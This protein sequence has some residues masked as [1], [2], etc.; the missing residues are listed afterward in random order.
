MAQNPSN[1]QQAAPRLAPIA[2]AIGVAVV[3]VGLVVNLEVIAPVGV[4]IT[5]LAAVAWIRGNNGGSRAAAE[6]KQR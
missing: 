3:L 6:P 1:K 5:V 2:F 4:A